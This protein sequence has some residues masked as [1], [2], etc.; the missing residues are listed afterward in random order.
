MTG[1]TPQPPAYRVIDP[2]TLGRPMH[3]LRPFS[4]RLREDL[5]RLFETSLNRRY[6][7]HFE[8]EDISV[9]LM[10]QPQQNERWR[11]YDI[12]DGRIGCAIDRPL[13]L[14]V[15]GYRY[16]GNEKKSVIGRKAA[17]IPQSAT[18]ERL[19]FHL[20]RQLVNILASHLGNAVEEAD[21]SAE[22]PTSDTNGFH[23]P[24]GTWLI[25]VPV[26]E[27]AVSVS[28][29]I[30][31]ALDDTRMTRL[32]LSAAPATDRTRERIDYGGP[33]PPRLPLT[34]TAR[35]LQQEMSL[36]DL[37]DLKVGDII[38]IKM[39]AAEVLIDDVRLFTAAVADNKGKL[40]LT[41]FEGAK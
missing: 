15:M 30:R 24:A 31:F 4:D 40:C 33:L 14:V 37:L 35:L 25:T 36:G 19:E 17:Q 23:V 1:Q 9:T 38:P 8:V 2:R 34:L 27:Q 5:S 13:V 28:G 16:G 26:R 32:L 41:C 11:P 22:K 20:G 3:L 21:P 7:A 18:E 29:T 39:G 10:D 12:G 6:R